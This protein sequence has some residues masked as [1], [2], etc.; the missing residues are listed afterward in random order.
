MLDD[1]EDS[2]GDDFEN[3]TVSSTFKK[4]EVVIEQSHKK[5]S[6]SFSDLRKK[7]E[8]FKSKEQKRYKKHEQVKRG[9][10]SKKDSLKKEKD[11]LKD[12]YKKET[13]TETKKSDLFSDTQT[14]KR[15]KTFKEK[16][17]DSVLNKIKDD[18][19]DE[20]YESKREKRKRK[21]EDE[22][23]EFKFIGDLKRVSF[24]PKKRIC[25]G[26]PLNKT[27]YYRIEKTGTDNLLTLKVT[28]LDLTN[29]DQLYVCK[30]CYVNINLSC[31]ECKK[32]YK[33]SQT[34]LLSTPFGYYKSP[35]PTFF[36]SMNFNFIKNF[37]GVCQIFI[38]ENR[39]VELNEKGLPKSNSILKDWLKQSEIE[40]KKFKSFLARPFNN[41]L[42]KQQFSGKKSVIRNTM[43]SKM[44][45]SLRHIVTIDTQLG[46]DEISIPKAVYDKLNLKT[47]LAVVNRAPSINDTC[48]YT[49]NLKWHTDSFTTKI[50]CFIA[51][52]LH[53][54]QGDEITVFV[55]PKTNDIQN[56]NE[57][58]TIKELLNHKWTTGIRHR[59]DYTP[60]IE[61]G[62]NY[63]YILYN[64][65]AQI[66]EIFPLY[67]KLPCSKKEK[68]E[69]LMNL[70]CA[71]YKDKGVK[72][73]SD[74]MEAFKNLP[75]PAPNYKK[76]INGELNDIVDSGS[77][78]TKNHIVEFKK[79]MK[80][81]DPKEY[82]I[83]SK[84]VFNKYISTSSKM[85]TF[86]QHLD[87]TLFGTSSLI[88]QYGSLS[89]MGSE[90]CK[91]FHSKKAATG[92]QYNKYDIKLLK[93]FLLED[94]KKQ[95]IKV[96]EAKRLLK[97][98][99]TSTTMVSHQTTSPLSSPAQPL[100]PTSPMARPIS[101]SELS[102]TEP[103]IKI[104]PM[105]IKTQQQNENVFYKQNMVMIKTKNFNKK[106]QE[107]KEIEEDINTIA[108]I[109]VDYVE[110]DD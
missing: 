98:T 9:R 26:E 90:I 15:N 13:K 53:A 51:D 71:S 101:P 88:L 61:F 79:M 54:V 85:S 28:D 23:V 96:Q 87:S 2:F 52:G 100:I 104:K 7:L 38:K 109:E 108:S 65:H 83:K 103:V 20:K 34:F 31:H 22:D 77:K 43:L 3:E 17:E 107:V 40:T 33:Y 62:Q 72:V 36:S 68:P 45:P 76:I 12:G 14:K 99:L 64:F 86:D 4:K 55:I 19:N 58:L 56:Y 91:D 11:L 35:P 89:Y 25:L 16:S 27:Y 18:L 95:Q 69:F 94:A 50:S 84:E 67:E 42:L 32:F 66:C 75:I 93:H 30:K 49:V 29:L 105:F 46:P 106:A 10:P 63:L 44:M 47:N 57:L 37:I 6:D 102:S 48:I 59:F 81:L 1:M 39:H 97:S 73:L 80:G 70:L 21:N 41:G 8:K 78:G 92:I 24:E 60:K 82:F 74:I 110:D 5:K